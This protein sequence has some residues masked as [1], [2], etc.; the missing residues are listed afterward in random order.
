MDN[1]RFLHLRTMQRLFFFYV[2][3]TA[4]PLFC[5]GMQSPPPRNSL[6]VAPPAYWPPFLGLCIGLAAGLILLVFVVQYYRSRLNRLEQL[7]ASRTAELSKR[8]ALYRTLVDNLQQNIILKDREST[9]ISANASFCKLMG[10]AREDIPGKTDFDFIPAEMAEKHRSYDR[11]VITSGET[12]KIIDKVVLNDQITWV[13]EVKTPVRS[14]D[15]SVAAILCIFWD[16]TERIQTQQELQNKQELLELTQKAAHIGSWR[17]DY[18]NRKLAW[19]DETY[20]IFGI[21]REACG[22]NYDR[23][24]AMIHPGDV[25]QVH[26]KLEDS[27]RSGNNILCFDHRIVRP[28]GET[29]WVHERGE[30]LKNDRGDIVEIAGIVHDVTDQKEAEIALKESET[31][32]RQL[33][34]N[35]HDVFWMTGDDLE[36][37]IFVSK[38]Y[39]AVWGRSRQSL[40]GDSKSF[41]EAIHPEDLPRILNSYKNF[42]KTGK[43]QE[44]YRILRPDGEIRWILDRGAVIYNEDGQIDRAV[45]IA[46]DITENK[47]LE[48]QFHQSQKIEAIGKLA[49]GVAHDFNNLIMS[50]Q[51]YAQFLLDKIPEDD[52]MRHDVDGILRAS[53]RAA[54]LTRQLLAFSRK[55]VLQPES[56]NLNKLIQDLEKLLRRMIREDIELSAK[57]DEN[58]GKIKADPS[59][60]EQIVMNLAVNARDAMPRGGKLTLETKNVYLDAN[61]SR[62]HVEVMPGD[63]VM[64]SMTDTGCGMDKPTLE[65][66]FDPFFT[67]KEV[68]KGTGLGLSTVYGIVKQSGGHIWVYSEPGRGSAFKLYFPREIEEEKQPEADAAAS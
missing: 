34:N 20:R 17:L 58:L 51:G 36:T 3:L 15:G 10:V 60:I 63:Y 38:A 31:R 16:I 54:S 39:E 8:E 52:P 43:F 47:R 41:V 18:A 5:A 19:S 42:I 21:D 11:Q 28:N 48:E 56:L 50:I 37:I 64:L 24:F 66:I 7:A 2:I 62:D 55:Q 1:R 44:E 32:F 61:Y 26:Q 68:G 59:Q 33:V 22:E 57:F 13:E 46:K 4:F 27:A 25:Q 49:G 14:Q 23:F 40:Y 67:T 65:Q 6:P 9:F 45:G 53:E 12:L 30:I 29:R 35:L